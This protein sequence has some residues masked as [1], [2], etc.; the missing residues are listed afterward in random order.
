MML[1][2]YVVDD[3]VV[4]QERKGKGKTQ[5]NEG[6]VRLGEGRKRGSKKQQRRKGWGCER[7]ARTC[8]PFGLHARLGMFRSCSFASKNSSQR[9]TIR[10]R[11]FSIAWR[12]RTT[13]RRMSSAYIRSWSSIICSVSTSSRKTP[14]RVSATASYLEG[15]RRGR[16]EA[17]VGG[18]RVSTRAARANRAVFTSTNSKRRPPR[19]C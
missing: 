1:L 17:G 5:T 3:D 2:L 12:C 19:T 6:V 15:G 9:S 7:R 14:L 13:S 4:E 16:T 18:V 10:V 8:S 11:T